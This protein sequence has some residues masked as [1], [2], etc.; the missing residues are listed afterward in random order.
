M[1]RSVLNGCPSEM[2]EKCKFLDIAGKTYDFREFDSF[3]KAWRQ[4]G[5]VSRQVSNLPRYPME[6]A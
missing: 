5:A 6:L 3:L 1:I 4:I 2:A